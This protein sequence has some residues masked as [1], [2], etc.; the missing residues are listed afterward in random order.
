LQREVYKYLNA[1]HDTG[2][3]DREMSFDRENILGRLIVIFFK[4]AKSGHLIMH[5]QL[6]AFCIHFCGFF[7]LPN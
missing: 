3:G 2:T 4:N 7:R 5:D 6:S 1:G